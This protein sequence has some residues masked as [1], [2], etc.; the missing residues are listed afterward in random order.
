MAMPRSTS[1]IYL[2]LLATAASSGSFEERDLDGNGSIDYHEFAFYN[3]DSNHDGV[4]D[5][6][7]WEEQAHPDVLVGLDDGAQA[8]PAD[9]TKENPVL[10]FPH[11]PTIPMPSRPNQKVF[12]KARIEGIPAK[13]E[14]KQADG[15]MVAK[16]ITL[17]ANQ[18][19][20][21]LEV[22]KKYY[23]DASAIKQINPPLRGATKL[24]YPAGNPP[25]KSGKVWVVGDGHH[26][27]VWN[28]YHK[29]GTKV[30]YEL[31]GAL[32]KM[33]WDGMVFKKDTA[34]KVRNS[35]VAAKPAV[36]S[37]VPADKP[38]PVAP[39]LK[40]A[41]PA[42][43]PAAAAGDLGTCDCSKIRAVAA[44]HREQCEQLTPKATSFKDCKNGGVF[45][46]NAELYEEDEAVEDE[47]YEGYEAES[48]DSF[49]EWEGN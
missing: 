39:P 18:N 22:S 3:M 37:V 5:S 35:V 20:L 4:I 34:A 30:G 8:L 12:G 25:D 1:F 19:Y 40:L 21:S 42:A 47:G 36:V 45:T 2:A 10:T 15:T 11:F 9:G 28:A 33:P 7:E 26:R 46:P 17:W 23:D 44:Y 31:K 29:I 24:S 16:D 13:L 43:R 14:W 49:E 27:V 32:A 48:E 6:D 41:K 38:V